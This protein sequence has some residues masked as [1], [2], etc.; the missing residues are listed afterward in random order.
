MNPAQQAYAAGV[1]R[2]AI[3]RVA[4]REFATLERRAKDSGLR[5]QWDIVHAVRAE[6]AAMVDRIAGDEVRTCLDAR[7]AR[8]A[9]QDAVRASGIGFRAVRS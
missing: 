3:L 1:A 8:E 2:R 7:D 9:R 5:C 6:I 4:R